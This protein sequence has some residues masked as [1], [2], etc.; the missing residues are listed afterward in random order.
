MRLTGEKLI[1]IWRIRKQFFEDQAN[2]FIVN[3][4]NEIKGL[5][6]VINS[7][8]LEFDSDNYCII[9]GK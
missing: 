6:E 2:E 4:F 8:E 5:F 1:A 9:D 3:R 7:K